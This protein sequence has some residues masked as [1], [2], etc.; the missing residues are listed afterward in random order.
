MRFPSQIEMLKGRRNSRKISLL[1]IYRSNVLWMPCVPDDN[2]TAD[3]NI[4]LKINNGKIII[5]ITI[6]DLNSVYISRPQYL[7][8]SLFCRMDAHLFVYITSIVRPQISTQTANTAKQKYPPNKMEPSKNLINEMFNAF[9]KH[10]IFL[11]E[12]HKNQQK[13]IAAQK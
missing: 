10:V 6:I 2:T 9:T 3:N 1:V 13:H 5:I 7:A 12:H 11:Q 8:S 4:R